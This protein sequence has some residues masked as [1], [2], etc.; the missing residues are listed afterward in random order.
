MGFTEMLSGIKRFWPLA[1]AIIAIP[2]LVLSVYLFSN[3]SFFSGGPTRE[4]RAATILSQEIIDL[5]GRTNKMIASV[6]LSDLRG[7]SAQARSLIEEAHKNNNEAFQRAVLLAKELEN[8]TKAIPEISSPAGQRSAYDLVALESALIG[9]FISYTGDLNR[10]LNALSAAVATNNFSDRSLVEQNLA[11]V[12]Q[13]I[14]A[15]NRISEEF[16]RKAAF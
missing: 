4:E 2:L 14:S 6:N 3:G 11:A 10:F 12:N 9:E 13:R 5:T 1:A 15:I 16:A 8:W 7:D